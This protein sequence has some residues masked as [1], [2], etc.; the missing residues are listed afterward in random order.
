MSNLSNAKVFGGIG[1]ILALVGILFM[2]LLIVGII[3]VFIA[4]KYISDE[5]KDKEIFNNYLYSF[6]LNIVAWIAILFIFLATFGLIFGFSMFDPSQFSNFTD[7]SS[8]E[9]NFGV[10]LGGFAGCIIAFIVG[11]I[12]FIFSAIYL[13]KSYNSIT[14]HTKVDLFKTTG[15]INFIGALTIIIGI[16]I[17]ILLIARIIEIIA[18]F[19][20][21]E[22]LP[23]ATKAPG[24]SE[25]PES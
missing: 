23:K 19:S 20:L 25:V 21:P 12:L 8:F 17:L 18:F 10:V 3:L 1:A 2:P 4:V 11:W 24:T 7:P 9:E 5:A 16:G 15:L 22:N 13:R 6:I 14:E